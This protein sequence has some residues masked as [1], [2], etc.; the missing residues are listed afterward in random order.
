M[1]IKSETRAGTGRIPLAIRTEVSVLTSDFYY[2][3][4]D[5]HV[6]GSS[7]LPK[8]MEKTY[9]LVKAPCAKHKE[10]WIRCPFSPIGSG[11]LS[12]ED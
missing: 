9:V 8:A 11:H 10:T 7:T 2:D 12:C 5:E 4:C 6:G 3:L 1:Q